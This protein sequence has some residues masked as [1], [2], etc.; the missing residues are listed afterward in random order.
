MAQIKDWFS[1][2]SF[3]SLLALFLAGL[4]WTSGRP[5][6]F[7]WH[8]LALDLRRVLLDDF[9]VQVALSNWPFCALLIG[10]VTLSDILALFFKSIL[11]FRHIILDLVLV[12]PGSAFRPV[13]SGTFDW[14]RDVAVPYQGRVTELDLFI[15]SLFLVFDETLFLEVFF[16]FFLLLWLVVRG[17]G[18][19][20]LLAVAVLAVDLIVILCLL[21]HH[22]FVDATVA[23]RGNRSDVQ[24]D[25]VVGSLS[26]QPGVDRVLDVMV[27]VLFF[28]VMMVVVREKVLFRTDIQK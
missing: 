11:T 25:L 27:M 23:G 20:A 18:D 7:E 2:Y 9:S 10:S 14:P 21:N 17:V 22:H 15:E 16:A 6:Q 1:T 19:V 13:F 12:V 26:G 3:F 8:L 5:T 24:R 28:V 4:D